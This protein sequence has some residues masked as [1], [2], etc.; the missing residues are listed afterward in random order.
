MTIPVNFY[1]KLFIGTVKIY[2]KFPNAVLSPEF[3]SVNL[4][5]PE[6]I[7]DAFFRLRQIVS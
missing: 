1:G 6:P 2:Y 7:P 5:S 4:L 3:V